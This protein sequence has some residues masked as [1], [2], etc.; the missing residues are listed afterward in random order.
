M[1]K[2]VNMY[3]NNMKEDKRS[4]SR[5]KLDNIFKKGKSKDK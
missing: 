2:I 1:I 5:M 3:M 4:E